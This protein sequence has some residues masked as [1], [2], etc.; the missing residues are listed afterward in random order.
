M[1][2]KKVNVSGVHIPTPN[3]IKQH[4]D[5]Y[6]I[7]QEETKRILAVAVYNHYKKLIHN[8]QYESVSPEIEKSNILIMGPTGSG[9]TLMVRTIAT[10]LQV[11]YYIQ[12]CT[13]LTAS[14]YVGSDVEDCVAG[15]L[16]A[17][18]YD[19]LKAQRGIVMLDE[20]DKI[21]KK[22][23]GPSIIR[24]VSGECVQQSLLKI[25]EGD[26]VGVQPQGGRK[27]PEHPLTYIDTSNILFIAS[28]AFVGLEN[29]TR[30]RLDHG[31]SRI[32]YNNSKRQSLSD[33]AV[34]SYTST[35][36][37]RSFGFIPEFIGRFPIVTSTV[38]LEKDDLRRILTEP[39][40]SIINQYIELLDMDNTELIFDDSAIDEMADIAYNLG[41]GARALRNI[42]ETVMTDIMFDA[43][44]NIGEKSKVKLTID[45]ET[46]RAKASKKYRLVT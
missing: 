4:L 36:D 27:H 3:E 10:M 29:I 1:P 7:G 12:D 42:V 46:V 6:V 37:L 8:Y 15:L 35:D 22:G 21:A 38:K 5:M 28:G 14:G 43:P 23:A 33:D 9:K 16:R 30:H 44:N 11:P 25:V 41:I 13:K 18:N 2:K 17:S 40:R 24:D 34:R 31:R 19:V 39:R 32:G 20:I 45:R 26:L